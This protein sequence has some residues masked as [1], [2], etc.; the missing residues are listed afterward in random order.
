MTSN[1][2]GGALDRAN[3]LLTPREAAEYSR[4]T[5]GQL[6]QLRYLGRGPVY[7]NP[8]PRRILYRRSDIDTWLFASERRGTSEQLR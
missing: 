3:A 7:L 6:A 1:V 8:T 4:L 5:V 2:A